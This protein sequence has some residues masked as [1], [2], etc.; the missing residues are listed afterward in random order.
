MNGHIITNYA[1]MHP[2]DRKKFCPQ[3]GQ[4]TILACGSCNAS[5]QG[6]EIDPE[7]VFIGFGSTPPAYCH[8]CGVAHPW[9][10][11]RIDTAI[12]MAAEVESDPHE[13]EKLRESIGDLANETPRTPLAV[14][15]FK[16]LMGKAGGVL[17]P[18]LGKILADIANEAIQKQLGLK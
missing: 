10:K 4:P 2:E 3:C 12:E 17:G 5:L 8:E 11:R 7:V 16:K 18:A 6:E 14:T 9:T 13:L 15:R 1:N